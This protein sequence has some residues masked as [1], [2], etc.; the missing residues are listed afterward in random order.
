MS[1]TQDQ[2]A[3]LNERV[4]LTIS[5]TFTRLEGII[6]SEAMMEKL[7]ATVLRNRALLE[8]MVEWGLPRDVEGSRRYV[9]P[10]GP[11]KNEM[12]GI[13]TVVNRA[14]LRGLLWGLWNTGQ[15]Y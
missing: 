3:A 2:K 13:Y 1:L 14:H 9:V 4:R 10:A 8:V 6:G 5:K 7:V 15:M 11:T 12:N